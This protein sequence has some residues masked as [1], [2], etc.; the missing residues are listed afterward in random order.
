VSD[1]ESQSPEIRSLDLRDLRWAL[2]CITT[3]TAL[4]L[5]RRWHANGAAG[6][7]ADAS[8][9]VGLGI[10]AGV[11][12]GVAAHR[13]TS[14][15]STL[16]ATCFGVA[17]A[18]ASIAVSAFTNSL[19]LSWI[20][21]LISTGVGYVSVARTGRR[22]REGRETRTT[23]VDRTRLKTD[24]T[25]YVADV[26]ADATRYVADVQGRAAMYVADAR[27]SATRYVA[28]S[29]ERT[30]RYA[31]DHGAGVPAAS[32]AE[33]QW[34]RARDLDQYAEPSVYSVAVTDS[35]PS[36]VPDYIPEHFDARPRTSK[37]DQSAA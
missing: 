12:G 25:R 14:D 7:W 22:V 27:A 3:S 29:Q 9:M 31:V 20:M 11:A 33:A 23:A 13:S 19:D 18:C 34:M 35:A 24:A 21:W 4:W 5:A 10:A 36:R 2:P 6:S 37:T 32:L 26:Q 17:G 15:D 8:L 1:L 28:D 30:I 16:A